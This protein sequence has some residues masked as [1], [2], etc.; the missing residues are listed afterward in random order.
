MKTL[1][2]IIAVISLIIII[3]AISYLV[4]TAKALQNMNIQ[5][6]INEITKA[7]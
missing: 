5:E 1:S 7:A 3:L 4:H 2:R 6:I